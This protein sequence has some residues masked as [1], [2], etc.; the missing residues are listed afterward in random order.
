MKY[1]VKKYF[2]R[3]YKK[4]SNNE[5]WQTLGPHYLNVAIELMYNYLKK[6]ECCWIENVEISE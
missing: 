6:G 5:S 1:V 4:N 3:I 2:V